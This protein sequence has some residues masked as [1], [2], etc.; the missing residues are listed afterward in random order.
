MKYSGKGLAML[1]AMMAATAT[2]KNLFI[3]PNY[4]NDKPY[5]ENQSPEAKGLH[6]YECNGHFFYAHNDKE[7]LKRAKKKGYWT[8]NA[9]IK[10]INE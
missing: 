3:F 5:K 9:E 6:E 4:I 7:A 10:Q 8:E 2:D 1:A